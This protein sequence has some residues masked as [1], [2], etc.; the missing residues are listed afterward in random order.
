VDLLVVMW[1]GL[2]SMRIHF[3]LLA[4]TLTHSLPAAQITL[5]DSRLASDRSSAPT[6]RGG[7][8]SGAEK[9]DLGDRRITAPRRMELVTPEH[10]DAQPTSVTV[11]IP[12]RSAA[13]ILEQ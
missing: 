8:K 1:T 3:F 6:G 7:C 12:A 9:R 13:V 11:Q 2:T 10:P 5:E 4:V